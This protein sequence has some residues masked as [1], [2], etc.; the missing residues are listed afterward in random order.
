MWMITSVEEMSAELD[1]RGSRGGMYPVRQLAF[2]G[3][4]FANAVDLTTWTADPIQVRV[5]EGCGFER[6]ATGGWLS[7]RQAGEFL[8]FVPAAAELASADPSWEEW[9]PPDFVVNQGSP[10]LDL[11]ARESLAQFVPSFADLCEQRPFKF[12]EALKVMQFEAPARALGNWM[13]RPRLNREMVLAA[14]WG[15]VEAHLEVLDS[16]VASEEA[17]NR[18]WALRAVRPEDV[19]V[20]L[21]LDHDSEHEWKPFVYSD[22]KSRLRFEPGLVLEPASGL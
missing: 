13:E 22:G 11:S 6:C 16:L 12:E 2:D 3:V 4:P 21:D 10:V 20:I 7:A 19:E 5:C 18:A 1:F 17:A 15:E 9:A 8:L 14:G